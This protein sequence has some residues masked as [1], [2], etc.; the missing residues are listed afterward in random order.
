[1][2]IR[3]VSYCNRYGDNIIFEQKDNEI[4]MSGF[5]LDYMR[6]STDDS[7]NVTMVD[8]AGGPYLSVGMNLGLYFNDK[9]SSII[10]NI[11]IEENKVIF[12]TKIK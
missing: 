6:T 4:H 5:S 10:E 2:I 1:M 11:K 3:K 8:P 9:R 12:K 7:G